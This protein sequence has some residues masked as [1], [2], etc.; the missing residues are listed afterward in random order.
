MDADNAQACHCMNCKR[1]WLFKFLAQN[2]TRAFVF[3]DLKKRREEILFQHEH[4]FLPMTQLKLVRIKEL[5]Q[6]FAD[7]EK[8]IADTRANLREMELRADTIRFML[9]SGATITQ[10]RAETSFVR[11]CPAQ[12]CRGFLCKDWRCGL[13][14]ARVCN[15]CHEVLTTVDGTQQQHE[16]NP[17]SVATAQLLARDTKAC[18]KC[19]SMIHK[20]DG[21]DM[22][23]CTQCAT[24][25]S[26]KTGVIIK[27]ERIHN[28]HYYE[29]LRGRA[30]G[31]DIPREPGDDPCNNQRDGLIAN[32]PGAYDLIQTLG[33]K[34]G[35]SS[36]MYHE[37]M[38]VHRG[39]IHIVDHC[40]RY[41]PAAQPVD[42]RTND[43]L[44]TEYLSGDISEKRFKERLQQRQKRAA[45]Q[46]EINQLLSTYTQVASARMR[47]FFESLRGKENVAALREAI[48]MMDVLRHLRKFINDGLEEVGRTY[49]NTFPQISVNW[50]TAV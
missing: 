47:S 32:L 20:I 36:P 17:D 33:P 39:I 22:M 5:K 38:D 4:T 21:C 25:F 11:A 26:W 8:A 18:P 30:N 49:M 50:S 19:A 15:K 24:P 10:A 41:Y 48:E 46:D 6:E 16:C 34:L 27:N 37:I 35:R 43:D 1:P 23:F 44:R 31:G 13:C 29:W 9:A 14:E 42:Y 12:D 28:P 3:G 40:R 45:K 7:L 2:L